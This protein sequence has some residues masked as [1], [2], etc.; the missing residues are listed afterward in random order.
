MRAGNS[1]MKHSVLD[2]H[3]SVGSVTFLV[4][5]FGQWDLGFQW[6]D[7]RLGQA[8][9]TGLALYARKE[10]ADEPFTYVVFSLKEAIRFFADHR[11]SA[12]ACAK[13]LRA[14]EAH[15]DSVPKWFA[16]AQ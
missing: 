11:V 4:K 13:V 10:M 8:A 1:F 2:P 15:S 3:A 5:K 7:V 16:E 9:T 6:V 12:K 14:A